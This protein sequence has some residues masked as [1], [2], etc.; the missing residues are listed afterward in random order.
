MLLYRLRLR[1][2]ASEKINTTLM[3]I[4]LQGMAGNEYQLLPAI[5][6]LAGSGDPSC[7]VIVCGN[8]CTVTQTNIGRNFVYCTVQ[9]KKPT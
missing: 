7:S 6:G 1:N 4:L 9:S 3:K 2:T 8:N 5:S